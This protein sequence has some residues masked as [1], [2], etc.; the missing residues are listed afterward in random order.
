MPVSSPG[1]RRCDLALFLSLPAR[2]TLPCSLDSPL[3]SRGLTSGCDLTPSRPQGRLGSKI[4][5]VHF[6]IL[7]HPNCVRRVGMSLE[8]KRV[9]ESLRTQSRKP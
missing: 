8:D 1:V 3:W 7:F 4:L 6:L 9:R 2:R 5:H